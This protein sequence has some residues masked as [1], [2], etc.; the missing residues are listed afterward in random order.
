MSETGDS[1]QSRKFHIP[2]QP[3]LLRLLQAEIQRDVPDMDR[4]SELIS[5]DVAISAAV[6]KTVNSSFFGVKSEVLSIQ[7]ALNMMGVDAT[8]DVVMALSLEQSMGDLVALPRFWDSA[9]DIANLCAFIAKRLN[10]HEPSQAYTLGLFHD[11]GIPLMA[12][13]FDDYLD[14]LQQSQAL[15]DENFQGLTT[16][17]EDAKYDC[18][19]TDMGYI[20]SREWGLPDCIRQVIRQHHDCKAMLTSADPKNEPYAKLMAVL[21][22]AEW[23]R[24]EFRRGQPTAEWTRIGQLVLNFLY[25]SEEDA[26]DLLEG[27]KEALMDTQAY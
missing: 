1:K 3:E 4:I 7:H 20:L 17:F 25:M 8:I 21:K 23:G 16:D 10:L 18:S 12:S 5:E 13:R 19:H 27:M 14:A 24:E 11:A 15:E 2:A 6:L 9:K 22:L 26:L